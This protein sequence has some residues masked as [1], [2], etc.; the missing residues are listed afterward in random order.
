MR[1]TLQPR[2]CDV[3]I[4]RACT[5]KEIHMSKWLSFAM[6][7]LCVGIAV[8]ARADTTQFICKTELSA[9]TIGAAIAEGKDKGDQVAES[10]LMQGECVFLREA[11]SVHIVQ[12]GTTYG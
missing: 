1:D 4:F 9:N 12:F 5:P 6:I 10:F 8:P 7:A 2:R 11:I 3:S